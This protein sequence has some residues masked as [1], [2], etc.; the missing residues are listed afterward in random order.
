MSHFQGKVWWPLIRAGN[1]S[2]VIRKTWTTKPVVPIKGILEGVK[3]KI[4][5]LWLM[6]CH[7]PWTLLKPRVSLWE[8]LLWFLSIP[9]VNAIT[10]KTRTM[11]GNSQNSKHTNKANNKSWVR[12]KPSGE[13]TYPDGAWCTALP[14]ILSMKLRKAQSAET[15][16]TSTPPF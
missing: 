10:S 12:Q 8:G 3:G 5:S 15:P 7:W 9:Q 6:S 1:G 16:A 14:S 2:W 11:S 13:L 4:T